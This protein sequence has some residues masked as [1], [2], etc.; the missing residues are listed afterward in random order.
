MDWVQIGVVAGTLVTLTTIILNSFGILGKLVAFFRS[1]CTRF[2]GQPQSIS[3]ASDVPLRTIVAI[4]QPRFNALWWSLGKAGD[5]PMLQ[6]VG[7]FNVTNTWSKDVRLAGALLRYRAGV[8]SR[9]VVR[10]D[11]LVKDLQSAYSGNYPIPPN[12]MTWLRVSF[13]FPSQFRGS[14]RDLVVDVAVIDQFNNQHWVKG[15]RFKH[16]DV[17]LR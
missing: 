15:L 13:D 4:P 8:L 11:L 9:R 7:D 5:I 16:P 2:R 3:N 6:V 17:A 1:V 14:Q 10:G 12:A